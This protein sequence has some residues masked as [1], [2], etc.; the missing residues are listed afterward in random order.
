MSKEQIS[1]EALEAALD[2]QNRPPVHLW[3]PQ[4]V[5]EID[6][7][8]D[9]EGRW[10]HE[11]GEIRREALVRLFSTI[12]R[13]EGD[14]HYLVTPVEKLKIKVDVAPFVATTVR[15]VSDEQDRAVYVFTTNVG[16]EVPAGPGHALTVAENRQ[17]GEPIPLLT[18][19][20]G[21]QALLSRPVFYE[22]VECGDI[23]GANLTLQSAGE[24]FVLG[25]VD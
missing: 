24:R 17:T 14:Q 1:L 22:V 9:R 11:G 23:D 20:D 12:L 19:R 25:A 8:I 15:Q 6:I 18:V 2:G 3:D 5:G 21:L 10:F 13:R 4:N 16:E 7:R